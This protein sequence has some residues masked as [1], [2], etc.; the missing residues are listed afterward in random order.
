MKKLLFVLA[1]LFSS[2]SFAMTGNDFVKYIENKNTEHVP[3]FYISG[4][5]DAFAV[6]RILAKSVAENSGTSFPYFAFICMPDGSNKKQATS[7]IKKYIQDN[8]AE[9]HEDMAN[10]IYSALI[11]DWRCKE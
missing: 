4:Y 10:I 9:N 7:I 5:L 11:K 8:P 2:S 6:N 1:M 3:L